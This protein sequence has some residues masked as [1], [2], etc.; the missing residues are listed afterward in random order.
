MSKLISFP[1]KSLPLDEE[2]VTLIEKINFADAWKLCSLIST[3][4]KQKLMRICFQKTSISLKFCGISS[5]CNINNLNKCI[6]GFLSTA[7]FEIFTQR[8]QCAYFYKMNICPILISV[9][10]IILI[11]INIKRPL[12]LLITVLNY[13]NL[14]RS[15]C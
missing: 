9:I 6:I 12:Y 5:K 8:E 3:E 1:R 13:F 10:T 2:I 4:R 7:A 15:Y 14:K 11:E